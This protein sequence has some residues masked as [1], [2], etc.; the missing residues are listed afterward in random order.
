M[1]NVNAIIEDARKAFAESVKEAES[2]QQ[3]I[4][5]DGKVVR[6]GSLRAEQLDKLASAAADAVAGRLRDA[7]AADILAG[8]AVSH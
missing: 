5:K 2:K 8:K 4:Q 7:V 6:G 1:S 3:S